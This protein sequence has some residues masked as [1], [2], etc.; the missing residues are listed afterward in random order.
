[1]LNANDFKRAIQTIDALGVTP[2]V[3]VQVIELAN[4]PNTDLETISA[5]LRKDG[6]LAADVM[7]ISNSPH[8]APATPHSN[9]MS[10][11]SHLGMSE[12]IQVVNLSLARQLFARDLSSYGISA[13]DYWSGSISAAL[14]MEALARPLRLNVEDAYTLGIL[15]SLGRML[16]NTVIEESG[17][18]VR[19]DGRQPVEQWERENVGFDFAEAGALLLE[20][21]HFPP[22]TCAVI[23]EQ[24]NPEAVIEPLSMLGALQFTRRLVSLTGVG[25]KNQ[26]WLLPAAD[27]FAQAS[28]LTPESVSQ[29][30]S[31]CAEKYQGI[32]LSV[33]LGWAEAKA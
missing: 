6:P 33:D 1:M 11:I 4:D 32:L 2:G 13:H 22:A 15:H 5:V 9:L 18:T 14:V 26:A 19:W 23:A 29:L 17:F 8:Y 20:H 25:F 3:L 16:I 30:V 31:A 21:W 12:V 10:A 27:P 24:L 28:G 7:R